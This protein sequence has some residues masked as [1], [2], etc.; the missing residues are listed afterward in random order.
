[1]GYNTSESEGGN[2]GKPRAFGKHSG[3]YQGNRQA[4]EG[5]YFK[6]DNRRQGVLLSSVVGKGHQAEQVSA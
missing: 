1:M 5:I 6:K 2:H 4:A 3:A